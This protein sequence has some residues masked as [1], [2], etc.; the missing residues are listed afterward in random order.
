M[1]EIRRAIGTQDAK[2]LERHAHSLKGSSANLGAVGVSRAADA[3]EGCARSGNLEQADDLFK[4][5][6]QDLDHLVS[7]LE[8]LPQSIAT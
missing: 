1:E 8:A 6:E 4:S 3:L 7:E 2:A 5:L